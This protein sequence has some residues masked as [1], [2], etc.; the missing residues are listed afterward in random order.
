MYWHIWK[1]LNNSV[2]GNKF[3]NNLSIDLILEFPEIKG[4][5]VRN[6]KNMKKF[7]EEY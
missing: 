5:S 3:I 7:A 2:W 4:L 1:N 6:L